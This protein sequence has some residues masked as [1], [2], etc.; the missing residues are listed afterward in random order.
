MPNTI[1]YK[2]EEERREA[3]LAQKREWAKRNKDKRVYQT[4]QERIANMTPQQY[5]EYLD[6]NNERR[7]K[8]YH[9]KKARIIKF[10]YFITKNIS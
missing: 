10:R 7:R 4:Y 3:R 6:K 9:E 5:R 1:K 2:T 8:K